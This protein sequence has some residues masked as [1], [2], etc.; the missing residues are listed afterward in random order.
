VKANNLRR[1]EQHRA[2]ILHAI[3]IGTFDYATTFPNSPKAKQFAAHAGELQTI[4]AYLESWLDGKQ[5]LLKAST[6]EG[7]KKIIF[8][9]LI[10]WFG[11]KTLSAFKRKD[12]KEKFANFESGNKTM[13]NI[14]SVL[15]KALDDA[16]EDELIESNPLA[17]WAYSKVEPPKIVDDIDPFTIAE[18]KL[19]L[20]KLS[21]QGENLIRFALWTG[22]RTSELVA[23]DWADVDF[24]RGV[25]VVSRAL[26]QASAEAETTKTIAGKREIKL[27]RPALEALEAQKTFTWLAGAEI[28]Q[29]PRTCKRWDGDAP[30]R[31]TLWTNA[32]KKAGVRYRNPYQTRH[33]YASMM[34]SSGEHPMW[35]AK[36][37]GHKDWTMIAR[38]YG[39]W[40]PDAD[41]SAGSRAEA[42]F[43]RNDNIMTGTQPKPA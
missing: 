38:V 23:L 18:Q 32:L 8:H 31:K 43:D 36:Q 22:M 6:Y 19:I 24:T 17:G 10:P 25:I 15:R 21:G 41:R 4:E 2:A 39:R 12:I 5:K 30:I 28:F 14:Q 11:D 35:V 33:T 29:N 3:T 27:L 1:A 7:Y 42:S 40:M 16:L 13:A 37:M 34:L 26:T 9:Q 20:S